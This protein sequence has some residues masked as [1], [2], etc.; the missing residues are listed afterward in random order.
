VPWQLTN[1]AGV[2]SLTTAEAFAIC[3]R[4]TSSNLVIGL[5]YFK[6]FDKTFPDDGCFPGFLFEWA[7]I[8]F[9]TGNIKQAE[10]KAFQAFTSNTYIFDKFFGR[11]I[12]PLDK[13]EGS[14]I[15]APAFTGSFKY[16]SVQ[17]ELGCF[18][19]WL[20]KFSKTEKFVTASQ[21]FIAICTRLKTEDDTE[22]RY[23]LITQGQQLHDQF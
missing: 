10:K 16:S 12:V 21:K 11:P 5:K 2:A 1:D 20:D 7:I 18:S 6:W 22:M 14:N 8:L 17:S 19:D 13:Y 4:N 9:Y 15:E 3:R 23:Y